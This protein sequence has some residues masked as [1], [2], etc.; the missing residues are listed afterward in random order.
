MGNSWRTTAD[1][2]ASWEWVLRCLDNTVGLAR[3]AG[4]GHWNDA[5]MLEVGFLALNA[6]RLS[7]MQKSD[8]G[9]R[10]AAFILL[11]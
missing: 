5:D 3:F 7:P 11:A 9:L 8:C 6:A 2:A 10:M 4:P 1:I